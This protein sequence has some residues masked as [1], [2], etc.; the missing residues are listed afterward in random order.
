MLLPTLTKGDIGVIVFLLLPEAAAAARMSWMVHP[1][2][3][4][5]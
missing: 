4:R 2:P 1:L 5:D 3:G